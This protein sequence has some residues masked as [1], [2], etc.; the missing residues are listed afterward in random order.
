[1][2]EYF[3]RLQRINKKL[4]T[5]KQKVIANYST[6]PYTINLGCRA[7]IDHNYDHTDYTYFLINGRKIYVGAATTELASEN[8]NDIRS[9]Y[10]GQGILFTKKTNHI[11]SVWA[12]A[13]WKSEY[14]AEAPSLSS[15][16]GWCCTMSKQKPH[17]DMVCDVIIANHMKELDKQNYWFCY[18]GM[19][20]RDALVDFMFR[21]P[22]R[23][24]SDRDIVI[25]DSASARNNKHNL[26]GKLGPW[27]YNSLIE[28]APES[29]P[30]NQYFEITEKT[31]KAINA[32]M[33]FVSIA[34]HKY[35][36]R[37]KKLGFKT[38]SPYIDESYDNEPDN[39][40]RTEMA[41][42]SLFKFVNNPTHL[43][44]IQM[45]CDHNYNTYG[46]I[47]RHPSDRTTKKIKHLITF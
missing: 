40:K 28:L 35:L 27:H 15:R 22:S 36:Y 44:E 45:I 6:L 47:R 3:R 9:L 41:V 20:D 38:F 31:L 21:K 7:E 11:N 24:I 12:D 33:P 5:C 30:G 10:I 32:R 46:K 1:M 19:K 17:R 37:L 43:G 16:Q 8:V 25:V 23:K 29:D 42:A 18:D 26:R 13:I 39:Y 2:S 4:P 34:C 14:G